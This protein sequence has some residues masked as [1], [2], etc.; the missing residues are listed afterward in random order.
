MT[1]TNPPVRAF[2]DGFVW[3]S[4]TSSYQ[5]EGSVDVDGRSPSIWDVFS[6]TPGR[7]VGGDTGDVA[8]EHYQ[9][10]RDDVALMSELGL[11]GYRFSIAW[12]RVLPGGTGAV[13]EA[14][15]DF[16]SRLVDELLAHN[17]DPL[18]TLYHWDLPQ[19]LEEKG[20]WLNRD[21]AG[22]FAEYAAAVAG[23]LGDRVTTFTTHNEPW[24]A[25]Y[26]GYATGVHAPGHT[27]NAESLAVAHHLNLAHGEAVG[28]LRD[29]LPATGQVSIT[30]NLQNVRPVSDSAADVA[31]AAHV[32]RLSNDIFLDPILRGHYP[33]ELIRETSHITDWSFVHDGDLEQISRPI[34]I[35]GVNYYSPALV[36]APTDDLR[37]RAAAGGEWINDP[38]SG[39]RPSLWP[40][41]DL[42]YALP[43]E[44]PYTAMG[45]RVE[46]DSLRELLERVHADYP[47]IPL[48]VTENGA[49]YD[50]QVGSDGVVHDDDRIAYFD[51]HIG[52]ILDAVTAGVPV[53]GYF[54]WSLLDNF[55]WAWGYSKR[56]GIVHVDF[57]T[58]QRTPKDSAHWY[59]KV[60]AANGLSS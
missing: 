55:E 54:A 52:A 13:N 16:Y 9:R 39:D 14:G 19:V 46:A 37:T 21:V 35:L 20:G 60:I 49:A 1:A 41:T 43:Q 40:G 59:S 30:L 32:E 11:R 12:S 25:A 36:A 27:N 28:A 58:Q 42:A 23:R 15:L 6:H 50:D 3:G 44:G 17:V 31:A 29:T 33:E 53:T 18:V 51:G 26:L 34:D 48:I 7:V 47:G 22:Y 8:V 56:F 2:P 57:D 38:Q 10:Y 4:A 45:W 5:I 24:C